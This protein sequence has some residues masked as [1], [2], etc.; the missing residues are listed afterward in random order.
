VN[1]R[2]SYCGVVEIKG[3]YYVGYPNILEDSYD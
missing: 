2:F 3:S 1:E